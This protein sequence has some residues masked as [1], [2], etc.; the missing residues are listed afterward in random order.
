MIIEAKLSLHHGESL[1]EVNFVWKSVFPARM[2]FEVFERL[3]GEARSKVVHEKYLRVHAGVSG[4]TMFWGH[5]RRNERGNASICS[6][7]FESAFCSAPVLHLEA[8]LGVFEICHRV[9]VPGQRS[10][11]G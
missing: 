2:N 8:L 7:S 6:E 4:Q 1:G 10:L 11:E 5:I 3:R 9:P